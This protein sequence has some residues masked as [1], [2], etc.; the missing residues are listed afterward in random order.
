[1]ESGHG[2]ILQRIADRATDT[3]LGTFDAS[4]GAPIFRFGFA[5][6]P[7]KPPPPVLTTLPSSRNGHPGIPIGLVRIDGSHG[8]CRRA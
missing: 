5:Q 4:T 2:Q 6:N 1:M 3:E 8:R 7:H